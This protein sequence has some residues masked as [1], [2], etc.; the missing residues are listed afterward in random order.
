MKMVLL[1]EYLLIMRNTQDR[2]HITLH[3]QYDFNYVEKNCRV[4]RL[5]L[6]FMCKYKD[7]LG[8]A[9][10]KKEQAQKITSCQNNNLN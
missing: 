4:S 6:K 9:K 5:I 7:C 3:M 10:K 1:E 8:I 2:E